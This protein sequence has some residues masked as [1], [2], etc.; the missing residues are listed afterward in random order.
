MS[1][2]ASTCEGGIHCRVAPAPLKAVVWALLLSFLVCSV[3]SGQRT[4]APAPDR[5]KAYYHFA[6]GHL[7]HQFAQQFV[8]EKGEFGKRAI[9]EYLT[10]LEHDPG[11]TVI[12]IELIN[13]HAGLGQLAEAVEIA[14]WILETDTDNLEVRRLLGNI[15]RLFATRDRR[16]VNAELLA[17][18]VLQFERIVE[19][20]P[21]NF[22]NHVKLGILYRSAGQADKAEKAFRRAVELDP[23]QAEAQ[24]NLAYLLLESRNFDEAISALEQI[25]ASDDSNHRYATALADAYQQVGR[26]HDA[27]RQFEKLLAEGRNTLELRRRLADNLYYSEQLDE[28]LEQYQILAQTDSEN[29]EFRFRIARIHA[30]RGDFDKAW[31]ALEQARL[32]DSDSLDLQFETLGLLEAEGRKHEAVTQA[33]ALLEKT[34]KKEYSPSERNARTN[35]TMRLGRLQRQLDSTQDAITTFQS[36]LDSDPSAGHQAT[37]Q[38]VETW[39]QAGNFARAEREARNAVEG[40]ENDPVLADMLARVLSDRGKTREAIKVI[41]RTI[42]DG[43]PDITVLLAMARVYVQGRHF[44]RAAEHIDQADGLADSDED[45]IEVLFAYGS[46][47]ERAKLFE[48]SEAS[49]RELLKIDPD[50]STALNYLG[51]M[52]A[53]RGVHL[54]EAHELIQ[55]ALD[56]EPGNGAYLDSL[57]WLYY[58]QEKFDLAADYLERSLKQFGQD[59]VV[60][61]H[62]GDVYFKQGRIADARK[63]W[64]L[65]LEAWNRSAPADRDSEEM[66]ELRRKLAESELSSVESPDGKKRQEPVKR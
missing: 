26:F 21:D 13:L 11:S 9:A 3:A 53:D 15:F 18:A 16:G 49:F 2:L 14:E 8:N 29:P 48:Q 6:L 60:H 30:Y 35:L 17:K 12:R 57:G 63:H 31:A 32:L 47:Y 22:E 44:D 37:A 59:P 7:Y 62:L 54:D 50:N 28:A 43:K 10:A 27:A 42:K 58:R 46:M 23:A 4:G 38:I 39:R 64:N 25:V 36:I 33:T 24:V 56:L 55:R 40:S 5:S 66:E 51:Y 34:R 1:Y 45:R 61:S 52:F 20:E 65:A 19:I 41:E